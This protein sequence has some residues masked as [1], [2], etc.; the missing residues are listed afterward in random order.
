MGWIVQV[1]PYLEQ[2]NV[3]NHVDFTKS[4]YAAENSSARQQPLAVLRCASDPS[5]GFRGLASATSYCGIH[6]DFETQIDVDQNGVL[7]LNSSVSYD[8]ITDGSSNTLFIME[9][10]GKSLGWMS[11]TSSSLRNAVIWTNFG[12]PNATPNY[13]TNGGAQT[14]TS[15][16][17]PVNQPTQ[18]FVGGPGSFHTGGFHV[19]VGDG[20]VRFISWS[21][22]PVTFRNLAHRAD[23]EMMGD[24]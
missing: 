11:G 6:N 2:R 21:I 9:S 23:G 5:G 20:S 12:I 8:Q 17:E 24:Y 16:A 19:A 10:G 14:M 15:S 7:F 1:L 4:V 22:S 13:V 3:F 18:S